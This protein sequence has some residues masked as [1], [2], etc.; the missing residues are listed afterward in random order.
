M[1]KQTI[2]YSKKLISNEQSR[3]ITLYFDNEN[4]EFAKLVDSWTETLKTNGIN[5]NAAMDA[6]RLAV[7]LAEKPDLI[8]TIKR[9]NRIK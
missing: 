8:E 6:M 3:L 9:L 4:P 5:K 7:M 1:S 2:V